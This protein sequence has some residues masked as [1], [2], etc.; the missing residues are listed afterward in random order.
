MCR[1]GVGCVYVVCGLCVGCVLTYEYLFPPG[2]SERT[3]RDKVTR[4]FKMKK[5]YH[6]LEFVSELYHKL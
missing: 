6:K 4:D 3:D 5:V 2:V 1:L